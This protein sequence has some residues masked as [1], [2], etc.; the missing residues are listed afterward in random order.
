[1][2]PLVK[3]ERMEAL[4][5]EILGATR[6]RMVR[7]ICEA[8]EAMTA[9]NPI[10]LIFEDLHWVDPATLDVISALARRSVQVLRHA[11]V[12][13]RKVTTRLE[14]ELEVQIP[15]FIG[16]AHYALGAMAD[17]A[18]AYEAG[19][20]RAAQA[21]LKAAQVSTLSCTRSDR[22]DAAALGNTLGIG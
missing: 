8:L 18:K 2:P 6:E 7:E 5:R 3:A 10:V 20:S 1:M 22:C 11:L 14:A 15:E 19:A 17:S 13:A 9:E 16:D 4:Q 12:L 21:D